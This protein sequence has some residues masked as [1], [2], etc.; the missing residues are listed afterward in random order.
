MRQRQGLERCCLLGDSPK[1]SIRS[2]ISIRVGL[3]TRTAATGGDRHS[4]CCRLEPSE[5]PRVRFLPAR[6][7]SARAP[8]T[9]ATAKPTSASFSARWS[10]A[11]SIS[12][13]LSPFRARGTGAISPC[14]PATRAGS[15]FHGCRDLRCPLNTIVIRSFS[16]SASI[17]C[18]SPRRSLAHDQQDPDVPRRADTGCARCRG[19][20]RRRSDFW[21]SMARRHVSRTSHDRKLARWRRRWKLRCALM[22]AS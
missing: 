18:H 13:S 5:A 21:R 4:H 8:R 11:S 17:V 7:P 14:P 6:S 10:S 12:D 1:I 2:A 15:R 16:G 22:S 3:S 9:R 19:S 20:S